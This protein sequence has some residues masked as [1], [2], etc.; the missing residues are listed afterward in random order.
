LSIAS[1]RCQPL[2]ES[3]VVA[4]DTSLGDVAVLG[5]GGASAV[6]SSL[7]L[8]RIAASEVTAT[9]QPMDARNRANIVR[10]S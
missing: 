2:A 7:Q 3:V 6:D 5:E 10:S 4:D 8:A 9:A 1:T